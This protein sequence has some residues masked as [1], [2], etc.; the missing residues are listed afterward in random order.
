MFFHRK[1]YGILLLTFLLAAG[2]ADV[3][4]KPY[5]KAVMEQNGGEIRVSFAASELSGIQS[6]AELDK[7]EHQ[8][9]A[10]MSGEGRVFFGIFCFL[11]PT[12]FVY[13]N[14][15]SVRFTCS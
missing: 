3:N 1:L 10:A 12:F 8:I 9:S 2:F 7:G 4:W 11:F 6:I 13:N 15:V 5:G 14:I